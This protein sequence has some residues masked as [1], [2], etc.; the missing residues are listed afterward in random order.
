[1]TETSAKGKVHLTSGRLLARN[2]IWNLI[3]G[4]APS[5]VA[6]FSIPL[7]IQKL[8]GDRFGVLALAW[9]LI[10]YAGL[11]DMGLGRALT[12]LVAKKLGTG[13]HHEVP[14]LVWTSLL[15]MV[16]IG[17]AGAGII[18][19]ISPWLVRHALKIPEALQSETLYAFY[20]LALSV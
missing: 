12:Q 16:M 8:G 18:A 7:L 20:L 10:G 15:L 4:C 2:T 19:A 3:G 1:M 6:L 13:E 11:F 9:A 17:L 5:L 14:S